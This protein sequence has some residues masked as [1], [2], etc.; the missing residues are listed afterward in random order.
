MERESSVMRL[1]NRAGSG[2]ALLEA[3]GAVTKDAGAEGEA[4]PKQ[5]ESGKAAGT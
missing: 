5:L 1:L 2:W 3:G 4:A